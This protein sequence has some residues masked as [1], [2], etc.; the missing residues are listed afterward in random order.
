MSELYDLII[1]GAGP[2][3]MCAAIYAGRAELKNYIDDR[4]QKL[5][6]MLD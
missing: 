1:I 4:K 5:R 3:G 2:A 6:G